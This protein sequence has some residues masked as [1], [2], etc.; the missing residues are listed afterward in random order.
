MTNR[1][2]QIWTLNN[3][4]IFKAPGY[5]SNLTLKYYRQNELRYNKTEI[6]E[7]M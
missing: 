4:N 7:K 2:V 5:L 3:R 1:A 6:P